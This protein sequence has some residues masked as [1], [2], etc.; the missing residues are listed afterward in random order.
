MNP[1]LVG[2]KYQL[3]DDSPAKQ[4][5]GQDV[6]LE[7]QGERYCRSDTKNFKTPGICVWKENGKP[8]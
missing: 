5:S 2:G 3:Q 7:G 8:G 1:I 6:M 4:L